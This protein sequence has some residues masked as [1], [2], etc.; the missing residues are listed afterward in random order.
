[1]VQY[2]VNEQFLI[3][4]IRCKICLFVWWC[5]MP[6]STISQ[7]IVAIRKPEN[8]E[9]TIDLSQVTDNLYSIMLYTTPWSRFELTKSVVIG[10]D[11]ID[12]CKSNEYTITSTMPPM[13]IN[14][15][16]ISWR[17]TCIVFFFSYFCFSFYQ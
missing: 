16:I 4:G 13:I 7:Y 2:F 10:T 6:L 9:K 15:V 12:S 17:K 8:P 11:Y 3:T 5:L 1:M 14:N